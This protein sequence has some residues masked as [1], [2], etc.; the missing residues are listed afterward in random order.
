MGSLT[1]AT[2]SLRAVP[3]KAR[4]SAQVLEESAQVLEESAQL[5]E[6]SAQVL[7]EF[8][9]VLEEWKEPLVDPVASKSRTL[10]RWYHSPVP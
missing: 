1:C 8:A 9:Q 5:L 3:T 10:G 4:Q 6:E 2:I 7:E